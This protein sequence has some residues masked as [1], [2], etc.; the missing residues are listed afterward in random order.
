MIVGWV[1]MNNNSEAFQRTGRHSLMLILTTNLSYRHTKV[2]ILYIFIYIHIHPCAPRRICNFSHIHTLA[3]T[4]T[5][6]IDVRTC[7]GQC[8]V[9]NALLGF[10]IM[11]EMAFISTVSTR[12]CL[13]DFHY[14]VT[15]GSKA[16]RIECS[17]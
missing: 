8:T 6:M 1:F 12:K 5:Y 10:F 11:T 15:Q 7:R 16:G 14:A 4:H 13:I 17:Q 2:Y 9:R 3:R